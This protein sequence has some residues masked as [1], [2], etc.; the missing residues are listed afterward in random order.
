[1]TTMAESAEYLRLLTHSTTCQTCRTVGEDGANANLPC[2]AGDQIVE[3][4]RQMLRGSA[5]PSRSGG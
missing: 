5:A 2:V 3:A 1:M 4:Y